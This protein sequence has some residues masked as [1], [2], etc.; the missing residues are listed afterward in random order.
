[1]EGG[2]LLQH[3]PS[4][5]SDHER[6]RPGPAGG[7]RDR[8]AD[9]AEADDGDSLE[10]RRGPGR[11]FRH[12]G[13]DPHYLAH[14]R[15]VTGSTQMLRPMAGAMMRSSAIKRSNWAGSNDCAPSLRA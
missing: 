8:P 5:H 2:G 6:L 13:Q 9:Q 1:M 15:R 12:D 10:D 14:P 11:A 4:I 3:A 7:Q